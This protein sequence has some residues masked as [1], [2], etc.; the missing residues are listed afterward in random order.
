METIISPS[1]L[2][3]DFNI[4]G[5][6]IQEVEKSGAKYL[7]IDVMDGIF[8][9]SISFGMPVITS[10]RKHTKLFFDVHL[11]IVEPIRD[12]KSVV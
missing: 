11:M 6:Q 5:E 3:A 9:P 4:L 10:V 1:I 12:R 7:H 8:V 2:A